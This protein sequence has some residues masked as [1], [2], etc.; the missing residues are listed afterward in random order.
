MRNR[1]N[2]FADVDVV[3]T[4]ILQHGLTVDNCPASLATVHIVS[5]NLSILARFFNFVSRATCSCVQLP[6]VAAILIEIAMAA[7]S[8][9]SE[10]MMSD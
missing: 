3:T 8:P 7:N 2:A 1:T 6:T 10:A 4:E 9:T 5:V